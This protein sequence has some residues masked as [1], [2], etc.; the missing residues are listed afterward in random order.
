[1]LLLLLHRSDQLSG[2]WLLAVGSWQKWRK[3][4]QIRQIHMPQCGSCVFR[5]QSAEGIAGRGVAAAMVSR[6][7]CRW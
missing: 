1:L 7:I 4:R 2:Y 6:M 5:Q 3:I